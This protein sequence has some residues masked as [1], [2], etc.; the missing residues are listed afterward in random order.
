MIYTARFRVSCTA[1]K[2][3]GRS[4]SDP[5]AVYTRNA[6][7]PAARAS[8]KKKNSER[9]A[10]CADDPITSLLCE[11]SDTIMEQ[12]CRIETYSYFCLCTCRST[13][14]DQCTDKRFAV[15]PDRCD[16]TIVSAHSAGSDLGPL[17]CFVG[18]SWSKLLVA[19]SCLGTVVDRQ[20]SRP[21]E[22]P[23][24]VPR[25]TITIV[26]ILH[27]HA[28]PDRLPGMRSW[29]DRFYLKDLDN[30]TI[31][32]NSRCIWLQVKMVGFEIRFLSALNAGTGPQCAGETL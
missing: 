19:A 11:L 31:F 6:W 28:W 29:P 18:N 10:C 8:K 3:D 20:R 17:P 2:V 1:C 4:S 22:Y 24:L 30:P 21:T 9:L 5:Q 15:T 7:K 12:Q 23:C 14:D 27:F 13:T 25:E 26:D 32:S 16:G